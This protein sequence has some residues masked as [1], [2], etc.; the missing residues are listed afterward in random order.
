LEY[1]YRGLIHVYDA[2]GDTEKVADFMATMAQWKELREAREM[3]ESAPLALSGSSMT[4]EQL[5]T[6]FPV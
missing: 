6:L 4:L 1:D 3:R 5:Q 2:L